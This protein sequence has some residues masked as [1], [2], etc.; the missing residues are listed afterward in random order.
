MKHL[1]SDIIKIFATIFLFSFLLFNLIA[2]QLVS[3]LYF[4]L[5]KEDK[6]A[7][8]A[9]LQK[10]KNLPVFPYF[11]DINKKIYGD[12]L[13]QE[14]FAEDNERKETIAKFESLLQK[15]QKSR[16]VLYNLYLLYN[17]DGNKIKAEEYFQKAKEIDP[18]I[19]RN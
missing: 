19:E 4:Q 1:T 6:N 15:N 7:V 18:A 5:T 14:V 2:S 13:E 11:L 16:D 10:I 3:P 17:E 8:V 9:F 12:S